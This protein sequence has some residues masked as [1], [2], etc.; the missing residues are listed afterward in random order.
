VGFSA[1]RY[2]TD[3]KDAQ[4]S[5]LIRKI[6]YFNSTNRHLSDPELTEVLKELV[7]LS[8]LPL[9]NGRAC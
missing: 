2:S 9:R 6:L 7:T 8:S 4:A 1:R 5:G 3:L